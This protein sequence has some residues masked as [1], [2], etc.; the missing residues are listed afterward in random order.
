MIELPLSLEPAKVMSIS[1]AVLCIT[2]G[3][4]S[5]PDR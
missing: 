4:S 1:L 3:N 2:T 5:D